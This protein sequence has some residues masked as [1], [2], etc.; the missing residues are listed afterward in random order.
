MKLVKTSAPRWRYQNSCAKSRLCSMSS[1]RTLVIEL[2]VAVKQSRLLATAILLSRRLRNDH[3]SRKKTMSAW[4][5]AMFR[6][7]VLRCRRR[8]AD[9]RR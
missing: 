5:N 8:F 1:L 4:E 3:N 9:T 7:Y 6:L 2:F